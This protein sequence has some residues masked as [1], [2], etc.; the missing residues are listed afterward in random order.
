[1]LLFVA[2][3]VDEESFMAHADDV[4]IHWLKKGSDTRQ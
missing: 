4:V 1:M 2:Q 3:K